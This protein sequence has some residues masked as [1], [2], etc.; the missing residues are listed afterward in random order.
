MEDEPIDL[1]DIQDPVNVLDKI[2]KG[3]YDTI[4]KII[5]LLLYHI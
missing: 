3:F 1:Y 2:P 4:V 5:L